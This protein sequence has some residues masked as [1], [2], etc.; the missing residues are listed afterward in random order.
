MDQEEMP[1]L[2]FHIHWGLC[3]CLKLTGHHL[4]VQR[5]GASSQRVPNI[6]LKPPSL[7]SNP[8]D[9]TEHTVLHSKVI[10]CLPFP[11]MGLESSFTK[12]KACHS[13]LAPQKACHSVLAPHGFGNIPSVG[14][15][16]ALA[17]TVRSFEVSGD[18]PEL[19][20]SVPHPRAAEA[21]T[22]RA[23]LQGAQLPNKIRAC[24]CG[25]VSKEAPETGGP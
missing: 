15:L 17:I 23:C 10:S 13:V 11:D 21:L 24:L 22:S 14:I 7:S 1:G 20:W 25:F 6:R 8:L 16:K 9:A 3:E 12:R 4:P 2:L 18:T 19:F 5:S